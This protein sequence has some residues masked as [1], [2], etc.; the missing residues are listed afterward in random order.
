EF[1]IDIIDIGTCSQNPAPGLEAVNVGKFGDRVLEV[2]F[3]PV[4]V[5]NTFAYGVHLVDEGYKQ[6]FDIRIVEYRY[7]FAV[8]LWFYRMHHNMGL[9]IVD[10]EIITTVV[11][12][13]GE[14]I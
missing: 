2:R 3:R 7:I 13:T 12:Q 6:G 11:T 14:R 4:V 10:P 1:R 9:E 5:N 8:E